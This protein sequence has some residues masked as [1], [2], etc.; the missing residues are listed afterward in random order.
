MLKT[1]VLLDL[2]INKNRRGS[3]IGSRQRT[4]NPYSVGSNP[5]RAIAG[6]EKLL[7]GPY[8]GRSQITSIK[9]EYHG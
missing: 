7:S 3:P 2:S 9:G 1:K 8:A 4:Q 6:C 5:T